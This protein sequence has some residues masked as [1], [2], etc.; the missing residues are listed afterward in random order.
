[1]PKVMNWAIIVQ[2]ENGKTE[3]IADMPDDV[4]QVVDDYITELENENLNLN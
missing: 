4:S 1:M 2:Y 3:E